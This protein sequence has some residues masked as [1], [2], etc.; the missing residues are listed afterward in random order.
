MRSRTAALNKMRTIASFGAVLVTADIL[1]LISTYLATPDLAGE[2]NPLVRSLGFGWGHVFVIH[3]VVLGI[4]LLGLLYF[5]RLEPGP[6]EM[7]DD[8]DNLA[9]TFIWYSTGMSASCRRVQ[10][11]RYLGFLFFFIPLGSIINSICN[12][13]LNLSF[14]FGYFNGLDDSTIWT[15]RIIK[16]VLIFVG[17]GFIF[18][19]Y[20][21]TKYV[22]PR[23]SDS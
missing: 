9:R 4:L 15:Y 7:P 17:V 12:T 23:F 11:A 13:A 1:D 10:P 16:M 14:Y 22:A 3:A 19:I 8:V 5:N 21:K 20:L 18:Y 2:F 6:T